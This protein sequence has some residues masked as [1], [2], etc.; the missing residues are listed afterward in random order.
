MNN[1]LKC[2]FLFCILILVTFFVCGCAASEEVVY[3]FDTETVAKYGG[4]NEL[5]DD[6][7]P[8][9]LITGVEEEKKEAA[10]TDTEEAQNEDAETEEEQLTPTPTVKPQIDSWGFGN[11]GDQY[12]SVSSSYYITEE[13]KIRL[14]SNLDDVQSK[15]VTDALQKEWYG[16]CYGMCITTM[17][18][19]DGVLSHQDMNIASSLNS[20]EAVTKEYASLISFYH[21]QQKLVAYTNS[22]SDFMTKDAKD[23]LQELENCANSG[24]PFLITLYWQHKGEGF[25]SGYSRYGHAVVGYKMSE[26]DEAKKNELKERTGVDYIKKI[27]I[28]D[29][30]HPTQERSL[31][32]NDDG[33][34]F[35]CVLEVDSEGN[36]YALDLCSTSNVYDNNDT[37]NACFG[38]I[39]INPYYMDDVNYITGKRSSLYEKNESISPSM[40]IITCPEGEYE[41]VTSS[42]SAKINGDGICESTYPEGYIYL[43]YGLGGDTDEFVIHVPKGENFYQVKSAEPLEVSLYAGNTY[44]EVASDQSG[45]FTFKS[46]VNFDVIYDVAPSECNISVTSNGS[47]PFGIENCN[48]IDIT[49]SGSSYLSLVPSSLGLEILGSDLTDLSISSYIDGF[50]QKLDVGEGNAGSLLMNVENGNIVIKGDEDG[51]GAYEVVESTT[52]ISADLCQ[53]VIS[54]RK[55]KYTG[56]SVNIRKATVTGSEQTPYYIYYLDEECTTPAKSHKNA[57]TYYVK[58]YIITDVG[59]VIESNIARLVISKASASLKLTENT[60]AFKSK[61]LKKNSQ[62]KPIV[63]STKSTG[64][65][66]FTKVSGA[67]EITVD[68]KGNLVVAKGTKKGTYKVVVKIKLKATKNYKGASI[69]KTLT[70]KIY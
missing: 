70:V 28:Y 54:D 35:Y 47:S 45:C 58:A 43:T 18:A 67:K 53:V 5:P 42:G 22:E 56:K 14:L 17:L 69:K 57:G 29:P 46:N 50:E 23:Q 61:S 39:I 68:K 63:F 65:T 33:M 20:V 52:E 31:Y 44:A 30:N 2:H 8:V 66:T 3:E 4:Y 9:A 1:K 41:I 36:S 49:Q 25:L 15:I 32:Y 16:S 19:M 40:S 24:Y 6:I 38:T 48:S 26:V 55:A 12:E 13:D 64:K 21:V 27:H 60:Y 51:D 37:N 62:K 59:R 11:F 34:W 10:E 7:S